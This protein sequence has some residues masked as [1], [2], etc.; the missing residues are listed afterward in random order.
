MNHVSFYHI[1]NRGN[2]KQPIFFESKNYLHFVKLFDKYLS[3]YIDVY[4]YCL[5]PNHFHF[6]IRLKEIVEVSPNQTS[7]VLKT[8]EVSEDVWTTLISHF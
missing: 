7:E 6:L 2:N 3:R 4:A 8:S 5:M 1:Y